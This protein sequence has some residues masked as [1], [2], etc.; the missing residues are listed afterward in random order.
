MGV[1]GVIISAKDRKGFLRDISTIITA[2]DINIT[3]VQQFLQDGVAQI[4]LEL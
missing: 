1:I 2:H 4:Y 3:Y